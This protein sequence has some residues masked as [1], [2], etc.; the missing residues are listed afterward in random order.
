MQRS[1]TLIK[2]EMTHSRSSPVLMMAFFC[3]IC[4][5]TRMRLATAG[6]FFSQLL[7][8]AGWIGLPASRIAAQASVTDMPMA[9]ARQ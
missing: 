8:V 4:D 6:I 9:R 1:V 5:S 2:R 7:A 3:A